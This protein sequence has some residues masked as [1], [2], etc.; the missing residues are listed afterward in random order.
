[1]KARLTMC[2][3]SQ[4]CSHP[5]FFTLVSHLCIPSSNSYSEYSHPRS[6]DIAILPYP[7]Y[8]HRIACIFQGWSCVRKTGVSRTTR[9]TTCSRNF[10]QW[11]SRVSCLVCFPGLWRHCL[12]YHDIIYPLYY[13]VTTTSTMMSIFP[14]LQ[15]LLLWRYIT[16]YDVT[17]PL[18]Y[19]V[20]SPTVTL[21][22]WR[23][24]IF[25]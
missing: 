13:D 18:Y 23:H 10:L 20:T 19:D 21:L 12:L 16:Y 11:T 9:S 17:S 14:T 25:Y 7:E 5:L 8:S 22:P 15:P 1:M 3:L 24:Q 2:L 6:P 4:I